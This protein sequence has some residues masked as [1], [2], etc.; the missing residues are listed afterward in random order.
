[1]KQN[2]R[3]SMARLGVFVVSGLVLA[4]A[5]IAALGAGRLFETTVPLHL[6][7]D[8]SVQGLDQGSAISYRGVVLGRVAEVRLRQRADDDKVEMGG[9]LIEVIGE[10]APEQLTRF[11]GSAPSER[12]IRAAVRRE[13]DK[14]LRARVAWKDITGQKYIDLEYD[15][16][17]PV[18]EL[19]FTPPG[20]NIPTRAERSL[21]DI[22]RDL[23][24]TL[25]NLAKV[26]Y[27]A[28]GAKVDQLLTTL[29][30]KVS[31]L[32]V[33]ELSV[34]LRDAANAIRD[35]VK[36]DQFRDGLARIDSVTMEL[37]KAARR[38]NDILGREELDQGVTDLAEAA[39]TLRVTAD[40]LSQ[41]VPDTMGRIDV[42]IADTRKAIVE[43]MLPETTAALRAGV[44]DF[45]GAARNVAA[46][47]EDL[48]AALSQVAT[49]GRSI[50]RLAEYLERHPEAVLG[51][52]GTTGGSR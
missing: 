35:A 14:G 18:P 8:E 12:E 52:R 25:A 17:A 50:A 38:V 3:E 1:M 7:F 9:A 40:H 46:A 39:R 28:L 49:A 4:A 47:R 27:A 51:G 36:G 6:Y 5:G 15:P 32:R 2:P 20:L 23:A 42:A 44:T 24:A 34:S 13:V 11:G 26:D 16:T 21:V 22:Q 45:S 31:E 29:S 43:A 41:S 33:D 48:H 37:E 30:L 19:G 10:L